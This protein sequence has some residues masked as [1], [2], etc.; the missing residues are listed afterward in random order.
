MRA[1]LNEWLCEHTTW[2]LPTKHGEHHL[3][4]PSTIY[5]LLSQ[6]P[7]ARDPLSMGARSKWHEAGEITLFY[8][9]RIFAI[10]STHA[11]RMQR[12]CN[13]PY[14]VV[15]GRLRHE[16]MKRWRRGTVSK[17]TYGM[18]CCI[19]PA[20]VVRRKS[21]VGIIAISWSIKGSVFA[22]RTISSSWTPWRKELSYQHILE[23]M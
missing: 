2:N 5:H 15:W 17:Y 21:Y 4:S 13:I 14:V 6:G 8:T 23:G 11:G 10:I 20:Y 3:P 16:D 18:G 22:D 19:R 7:W 9:P 12:W 1:W